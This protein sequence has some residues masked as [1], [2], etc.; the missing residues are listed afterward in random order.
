M[1]AQVLPFTFDREFA[2]PMPAATPGLEREHLLMELDHLR[3][4]LARSEDRARAEGEAQALER[5]RNERETAL[6]A[7]TDALQASLESIEQR[8][9]E[10]EAEVRRDGADLALAAADHLAGRALDREPAA[11]ID[12]AIGRV[13][14]ELRRGT[15]LEVRV[16]PD[17]VETIEA[18]MTSRQSRDRRTLHVTVIGDAALPLG[19]ARLLWERGGAAFDRA[20][21]REALVQELERTLTQ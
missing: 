11:A 16:C 10:L 5:F 7:A 18:M 2:A 20:A 8:F 4:E 12:E 14:A 21:R 3:R 1:T 6:L 9:E 17:L 19:D 15:P 13:L